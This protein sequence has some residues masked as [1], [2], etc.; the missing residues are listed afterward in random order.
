M[1]KKDYCFRQQTVNQRNKQEIPIPVK[2]KKK[3]ACKIG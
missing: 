3:C 2:I 1:G